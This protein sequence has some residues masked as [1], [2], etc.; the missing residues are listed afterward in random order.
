MRFSDTFEFKIVVSEEVDQYL[1][2]PKFLIQIHAENAVKHGLSNSEKLKALIINVNNEDG[3]LIIDIVDNGIGRNKAGSQQKIS[4]GKGLEIMNELYSV[5]NKYYNEKVSS[6]ITD[7]F[8]SEGVPSGT[9][10]T[11]RISN[12]YAKKLNQ[13]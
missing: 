3:A 6:Q 7:L 12:R 13:G 5:Y 1:L 11:I 9:K 4:T 8:D 2:V 10:V